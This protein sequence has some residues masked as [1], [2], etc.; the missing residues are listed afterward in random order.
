LKREYERTTIVATKTSDPPVNYHP[1]ESE[2]SKIITR[3]KKLKPMTKD[4]YTS[5]SRL[6]SHAVEKITTETECC[7]TLIPAKDVKIRTVNIQQTLRPSGNLIFLFHHSNYH[8]I[9]FF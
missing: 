8:W 7:P 2:Y 3:E 6:V 5:M 4:P 1:W 9:C